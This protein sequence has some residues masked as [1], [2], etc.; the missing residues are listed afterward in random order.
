MTADTSDVSAR[1]LVLYDRDHLVYAKTIPR[2]NVSPENHF[3]A[4][5]DGDES[6]A[7]N[8]LLKKSVPP[9]LSIFSSEIADGAVD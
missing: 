3:A 2:H 8:E 7:A 6:I 4:R 9:L 1:Y 5:G